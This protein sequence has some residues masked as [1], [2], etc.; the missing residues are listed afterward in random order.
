VIGT[1]TILYQKIIHRSGNYSLV[2]I[3]LFDKH[4]DSKRKLAQNKRKMEIMQGFPLNQR[5]LI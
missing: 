5:F 4:A 2:S 1:W 3:N